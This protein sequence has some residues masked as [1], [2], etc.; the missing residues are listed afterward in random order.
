[1]KSVVKY[2]STAVAAVLC[3]VALANQDDAIITFSTTAD[4]YADGTAVKDGE[5]YALCWSA[6][7]AFD[8]IT[9]QGTAVNADE[10]VLAKIPLAKDGHCPT[11]VFEVSSDYVSGGY[12]FVYLLDTRDASGK[13][14]ASSAALAKSGVNGSTVVVSAAAAGNGTIVSKTDV[15]TSSKEYAATAVPD[16]PNPTVENF[17]IDGDKAIIEV[18]NLVPYVKYNVMKGATVD[19]IK[20]LGGQPMQGKAGGVV[21]FVISK[22]D[23][24]FFKVVRQPLVNE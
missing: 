3:G 16:V 22:K 19:Q 6:D 24:N 13:P 7:D 10:K 14:A 4:Y 15:A 9:A 1:M 5:F 21:T 2:L 12:F 11:T 23:A 17:T 20:T 18:G 8:G